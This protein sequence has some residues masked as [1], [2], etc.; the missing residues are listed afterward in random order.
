MGDGPN[1][2]NNR[3]PNIGYREVAVPAPDHRAPPSIP[4]PP[5]D[6]PL[7]PARMVNEYVYCP[8]LAYLEWVQGEWADSADTVEGRHA[9][10]RVTRDGGALPAPAEV[11]DAPRL[12]AR[13]V[14]LSSEHLGLIARLDRASFDEATCLRFARGLVSA[15]IQ[16]C[17]TLLRRNWKRD[18]SSQP[19][20]VDLKSDS[21]RPARVTSLA[22]LLG[23]AGAAA[24]RY[25]RAFGAMLQEA[26]PA[27][28]LGFFRTR[29]RRPPTDPVNA[30]LSFAYSL[31]A[32]S[33]TV[34]LAAVGFDPF[35][36]LY[37]QARYGRPLPG[38]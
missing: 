26:A 28:G 20:L 24:A 35:R 1:C 38:S 29:N 8:R 7:V 30:L 25:F 5:A 27:P 11:E 18:A 9:H 16:N 31:L 37:H 21:R 14:T 23:V 10:R 3:I 12:H 2:R 34:A 36:G 4:H 13:S 19:V 32:R 33:W 22:E 17:R 6:T 15:K